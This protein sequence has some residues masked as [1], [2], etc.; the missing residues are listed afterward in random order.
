MLV[1][2]TAADGTN[3]VGGDFIGSSNQLNF[4]VFL[5]DTL[6]AQKF[7]CLKNFTNRRLMRANV[8]ELKDE[9]KRHEGEK[10]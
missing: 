1:R 10:S 2:L 5:H 8:K 4:Y 3:L 7:I 6:Y 9:G